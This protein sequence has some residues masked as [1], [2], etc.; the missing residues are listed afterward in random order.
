MPDG[1][2]ASSTTAPSGGSNLSGS[3]AKISGAELV[4]VS[5][6][7]ASLRRAVPSVDVARTI[8][9][10]L[11]EA[12]AP[13]SLRRARYQGMISGNAPFDD[14]ELR[15]LGLGYITNVNFREM[16]A[17]LDQKAAAF[18]ELFM[19]VPTLAEFEFL[20]PPGERADEQPR[21]RWEDVVAEEFTRTV[22]GWTGFLTLM[23]M[24]RRE[25]D[26]YDVGLAMW[27]DPWDWRPQSVQR[28]CFLPEPHA[29]VDVDTWNLAGFSATMTGY[30]LLDIAENP[31]AALAEGWDV[32]AVKRL[33]TSH[34]IAQVRPGADGTS[35]AYP[36][37]AHWE[38]LQQLIRNN[39]PS[40]TSRMFDP[41]QIRHLFVREPKSGKISHLIFSPETIQSGDDTFLCERRDLYGEMSEVIWCL[42][43]N[44]GDGYLKSVRGLA[45]EIEPHCDL[46]NRYLGRLFDAGML[47][48][49]VML[50]PN[51]ELTDAKRLQLVRVGQMTLLPRGLDPI[52]SSSFTPPLA[53]LV[54]IRDLSVSIMRNNTGVWRQHAESWAENQ[55]QKSARQVAEESAKEARLDKSN[56]AF[57]YIQ[58]ERLYREVFRRLTAPELLKDKTLPGAEEA[59]LFTAR[60]VARGVPQEYINTDN[61]QLHATQAI[62]MGSWGVKLDIARQVLEGRGM[63]D[64][65]GITNAVRDW[66]SALVGQ[67]NVNRYKASATRDSIPSNEMSIA[68]LENNDIAEGSTVVAGSDQNHTTHLNEHAALLKQVVDG[69]QQSQGQVGDPQKVIALLQSGLQ[70]A[71]EHL[72][73]LAQDP[74]RRTYVEQVAQLLKAVKITLDFVVSVA[75]KVAQAQQQAAEQQQAMLA[76]AQGVIADR[77]KAIEEQKAMARLEIEARKGESLVQMRRDRQAE[78]SEINRLRAQAEL[79]LKAQRQA[80][81][82]DLER[83][84]AAVKSEIDRMVAEAKSQ[85]GRTRD[86][87]A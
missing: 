66:L 74:A 17:I 77:D 65:H 16:K 58:L 21:D 5:D 40:T 12:D 76:E 84:K 82:L 62:G 10:R 31:D 53:P 15:E 48:G 9:K 67:R 24:C 2:Y 41:I 68:R 69:V 1:I 79:E 64:E 63:Y 75:E 19:E 27:A 38:R 25:A 54:Q 33:L 59:Q 23:D 39:E 28:S 43:Y 49:T 36:A 80:V 20:S 32:P 85:A 56:V 60:C 6:S 7:G 57:D 51:S 13:S 35:P 8:F 37:I 55:V 86:A 29:R 42:P 70:H 34:Y 52:Q 50:K 71:T 83:Q 22:R 26:A 72:Q 14:A 44:W 46:S 30:Q 81:E 78:S 47:A 4:L 73:A 45:A 87:G 3:S 18:F 61:L 11:E